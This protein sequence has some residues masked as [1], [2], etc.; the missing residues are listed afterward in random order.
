[1]NVVMVTGGR[2]L[3]DP[4]RVLLELEEQLHH[5]GP[6]VLV[7]GDCPTGADAFAYSLGSRLGYELEVH[8]AQWH[9]YGRSAGPKRNQGM[10]SREPK[11]RI[12]L[13]FPTKPPGTK[14][15]GTWDAVGRAEKAGIP[16]KIVADRGIET[17]AV[18]R[19]YEQEMWE[20]E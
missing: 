2:D 4:Q 6:H 5:E 9:R 18:Q 12:C 20:A 19:A 16:V 8:K 14:G 7:V 3:A 10:A 13:A 17:A 15:S 11:P 1:M